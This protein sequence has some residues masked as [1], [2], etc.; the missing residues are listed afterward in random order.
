MSGGSPTGH[1]LSPSG[2]RDELPSLKEHMNRS[3]SLHNEG[4]HN[5]S[6]R[7]DD[8]QPLTNQSD[9]GRGKSTKKLRFASIKLHPEQK[10]GVLARK[11]SKK[12]PIIKPLL[13][14][15]EDE[16]IAR[17]SRTMFVNQALPAEFLDPH[18]G[19][20]KAEY[21]R[22]KIRTTKYTP[23]SFFPKNIFFQ[24]HNL[25]NIY[26]LFIVILSAFPIF[27]VANPGLSAVPII[28]IVIITAIKD[29]IEDYR[30]TV[31][32]S[33]V[34]NTITC[35]LMNFNNPNVV[36]ENISLW[37]RFKKA[38]TRGGK[39]TLK[40]IVGIFKK[41]KASEKNLSRVNTHELELRSVITQS[42]GFVGDAASSVYGED[43]PGS[44]LPS[45]RQVP[46]HVASSMVTNSN[47]SKV[48]DDY[49]RFGSV[50]DRSVTTSGKA[51]FKRD[52]WKN[53]RC[54]DIVKVFE[55][56]EVPSDMV[57]LSTSDS[58]GACYIETKNLDGETNLKVRQ[59]LRATNH[60][61]HSYDVEQSIFSVECEP[62]N[63]ALYTFNGVLKWEQRS[64]RNNA[65]SNF[66]PRSEPISINN[67]LLRGSSLRNTKWVIGVVVYTGAESK[68]MLNSGQTPAKRSRLTRE[69]NINVVCNFIFLFV[70]SFVAGV[71]EGIYFRKKNS[72]ATFF[73]FGSI[74][75]S[76]AVDGLVTFWATVIL[77]QNLIPISLYISIEI[78]K[79][80]Q[81]FFIYSDLDMYYAP[82]DYPCTPK[83]WSIS[84]DVGQVEYIF[85]DKTGTLT[86]NVMEFKKCTI[87]GVPYGRAFT[88]AML[89]Q[90]KRTESK[91]DALQKSIEVRKQIEDDKKKML[92]L[93]RSDLNDNK[94]MLDEDVSFVSSQIVEDLMGKSGK[95]QEENIKQFML[96]MALCHTVLPEKVG[97]KKDRL[98]FKAQSPDEAALVATARDVGYTLLERT[99]NGVIIDIQ[100]VQS[101][102]EVLT[103]LE[104]NSTR[105]RMSVIVRMPDGRILLICKGADNIIFS[106]LEKGSQEQMRTKTSD[107]LEE[108]SNEGL[109][110]LCLAQKEISLEYY[111]EWSRRHDEASS[112]LVNRE[113][114]MEECADEIERDLLLLGGTA[115]E[116]RLQEGVPDT[117]ALL[118]QAGIKVW[119]LTG[120]KVATAINIGYSCNLLESG[121]ELLIVKGEQKENIESTLMK[122]L[123][124]NFPGL[125]GSEE[126]IKA[127]KLDHSPPGPKFGLVIDGAGLHT[128]LADRELSMK[129]LILCKQC[130][131]VLCCRVSPAQKA[132]VVALVKN[133]LDVTTLSIGDGAN[134][135]AMIQQADVGVGIAG[136]EGRQA[137]MTSDYAV[138]QFRYLQKLVLVHGRWSY[139]RIAEMTAN[140]FYKNV[141]FTMTL[142]WFS[143]HNSFDAS[144]LFDYT[145]ITLFNLAFTSLPVI[146]M[147]V[148]DQDVEAAVMLKVPELYQKGILRA[149]WSQW[150]FWIYVLDGCYESAVCYFFSFCVFFNGTFVN[151]NGLQ[152][153][154]LE[155]YGVFTATAAICCCNFYVL[156]NQYRW[157]W[158]FLLLVAISCLL[159]F[160]WTGIYT[161]FTASRFFYKA[162]SQVYSAVPFW[163]N[164][165]LQVVT[166]LLPRFACKAYQK[167]FL[168][169]DVDIIREQAKKDMFSDANYSE[170]E[171]E[172]E[173]KIDPTENQL[174]HAATVQSGQSW[175]QSISQYEGSR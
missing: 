123:T 165:L 63:P 167:M 44:Q 32:D 81:A 90:L 163:A 126:D 59:C 20:P 161:Q 52:Y 169:Y 127:A 6:F 96:A 66:V 61:K 97:V 140:L 105:K 53:I 8:D 39:R 98:L 131:S 3:D 116:D 145:Y 134:D 152:V 31:L 84:D 23:L 16:T 42:T 27:G 41:S 174:E 95:N 18:S 155:S 141:V 113:E 149:N 156:M 35:K 92:Y 9:L 37:R 22:N 87:N 65:M 12:L 24:F 124:T 122:F 154:N 38:C 121:M 73:E 103:V 136:L 21:S 78:V 67:L 157:D 120:D 111:N 14:L 2:S 7:P 33:E 110:T 40:G 89:G 79:T 160:F 86:Q 4:G 43:L 1:S 108:F 142:F 138:G 106:R 151:M 30:R 147:G 158:L 56:E 58:D 13:D 29:A 99:R 172:D 94:Y 50:I 25:A 144:Y 102:F 137:V 69:L 57:V 101:T 109:R 159:V 135:V 70:L 76:A 148:L 64:D 60:I 171:R 132:A 175:N 34:N 17:E 150:K 128:V 26:F 93:L 49:T 130:R 115:I 143:V 82:L 164:T 104:F 100:G 118:G 119:V 19:F 133:T 146:F 45:V 72:S 68:I 162:A 48:E 75:G 166:C 36:E 11:L 80:F 168:P 5:V 51:K 85:S 15:P 88:E 62:P 28:A 91:S 54:G 74:G 71:V 112:A 47:N 107:D 153:N 55:N 46:S 77:L 173:I 170:T 139:N 117:I 129:F 83:S 114:K 125:T 10:A